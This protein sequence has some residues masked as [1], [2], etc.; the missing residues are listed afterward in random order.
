MTEKEYSDYLAHHGIL[1]QKW[2]KKN[3]PPYP[4]DASDHSASEKK[5]GW[6]K[7]LATGRA[8]RA[9]DEVKSA[10]KLADRY[11][12]SMDKKAA[13]RS[14]QADEKGTTSA[15]ARAQRA[16]EEAK[17][18][19]KLAD[20]YTSSMDT[21]A[22][23]RKAAAENYKDNSDTVKKLL[24]SGAIAAG[25]GLAVYGTYKL[26]QTGQLQ[27]A[28]N[29]GKKT[30]TSM[31]K[32]AKNAAKQAGKGFVDGIPEG[33]YKQ[34]KRF[35]EVVAGG[36]TLLAVKE[37]ADIAAGGDSVDKVITAYNNYNKKNKVGN[38]TT[39]KRQSDDD[40]D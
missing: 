17:T 14:V 35:G 18:A 38:A 34:G 20:R 21:K 23:N 36:I 33:A 28:V 16:S 8:A 5:A 9:E 29:V 4:L 26:A 11:T 12:S 6:K 10:H 30:M 25:T 27:N 19:H 3:G 13:K 32:T 39:S 31:G 37:L 22:A 40:E 7:S 1:G 24:K 2:G 15:K